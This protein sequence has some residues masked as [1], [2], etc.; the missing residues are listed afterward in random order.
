MKEYFFP[1]SAASVAL[2]SSSPSRY[3]RNSKPRGLLGVIEF[4]GAPGLFPE[5]VVD[6][7]KACST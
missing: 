1:S 4:R 2:S 3:F 5:N 7:L 6:I